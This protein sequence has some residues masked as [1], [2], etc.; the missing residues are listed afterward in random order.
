MKLLLTVLG[1]AMLVGCEGEQQWSTAPLPGTPEKKQTI[2][3]SGLA[4]QISKQV[5]ALR[6]AK[7]KLVENPH[8]V[9]L[10]SF[11]HDHSHEIDGVGVSG[12]CI[13]GVVSNTASMTFSNV[14]VDFIMRTDFENFGPADGRIE[15]V[16]PNE[17]WTFHA[18]MLT[19]T[20]RGEVQQFKGFRSLPFD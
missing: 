8:M 19:S 20:A 6:A 12:K 4:D 1:A 5:D 11:I 3:H 17:S 18:R 15:A 16:G 13:T 7:P 14:L 10:T 2:S 9:L